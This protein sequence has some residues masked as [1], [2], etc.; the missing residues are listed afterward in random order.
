MLF[1]FIGECKLIHLDFN[2]PRFLDD[3]SCRRRLQTDVLELLT[4]IRSWWI[5][6][7]SLV[8]ALW[9]ASGSTAKRTGV[10]PTAVSPS[11]RLADRVQTS[12]RMVGM[13]SLNRG[14]ICRMNN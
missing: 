10:E 3:D 6:A 9:A 2:L 4:L 8:I 14:K 7:R 1:I 11:E 5:L 12:S 13:L